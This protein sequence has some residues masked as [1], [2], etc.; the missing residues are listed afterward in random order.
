MSTA[1]PAAVALT[2]EL[3]SHGVSRTAAQHLAL[4]KPEV[5]R[6][7]LEYL[8]FAK[9]RTTKGAWLANAI[10]D[11]YGPPEGYLQAK[12]RAER[13]AAIRDEAAAKAQ[14]KSRQDAQSRAKKARLSETLS[15][16]EKEQGEAFTAFTQYV[17]RERLRV[18]KIA[19]H[20]SPERQSEQLAAFATPV[21]RL[22]LLER[23]LKAGGLCER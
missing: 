20:L 17:G 13:E 9:Y 5:C 15:Q 11:E 12:E 19:A 10:R 2:E 8:P 4:E 14:R 16:M 3:I 23:W 1:E 7:C 22:E 21:R 18:A 6:R